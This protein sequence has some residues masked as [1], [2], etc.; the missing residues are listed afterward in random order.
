MK[1]VLLGPY[2]PPHGGVQTN[3]VAIRKHHLATGGDCRVVNLTRHRQPDG[4]GIFYPESPWQVVRLLMRLR[5]DIIHMHIGGDLS[6]RLV[7][8]G[9]LCT[10]L[11]GRKTVLTF[12]SGGYP[13]S[14]AGKTAGPATLRGIALRRFDALIGVNQ[15]LV[16]LFRK[17][18][19]PASRIRLIRPHQISTG[20]FNAPLPADL[21]DFISAHDPCIL[22]VSGLEP[23][24]EVPLQIDALGSV[25]R[26]YPDAGLVVVGSGSLEDEI[27]AYAGSREYAS[28]IRL[29]GD[30]PHSVTLRA[31][32]ECRLFLRTTRYD[33]DSISVREALFSGTPVIATDNGMRP[34]GVHLIPAPDHDE[35]LKAIERVLES[36]ASAGAS[37]ESGEDNIAEVFDL[38]RQLLDPNIDLESGARLQPEFADK[39]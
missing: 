36:G 31:I 20:D 35:L 32:R 17:F 30:L 39:Q 11:P 29:C 2:P 26:K 19:V 6:R 15:Q 5:A 22:T 3:L 1:L 8:L 12:H 27:R 9:L 38:Y 16:D 4:D 25:R 24:Y 34:E 18:G 21:A 37:T 7:L 23:E 14:E 28:H 13:D 10:L 33:G